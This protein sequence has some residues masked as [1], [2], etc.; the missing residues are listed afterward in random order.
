MLI[1]EIS[2]NHSRSLER[3]MNFVKSTKECGFDAIKFQLFKIDELFIKEVL[4]KSPEHASRRQWEFPLE[5]LEPIS[6]ACKQY[7][8]KLGVTPFYLDAVEEAVEYVD[9]F[10][11]ASYE[12]MW[13]NLHYAIIEHNMPTIISTGMAEL[14]EIIRIKNL[15]ETKSFD[16]EKL[17]FLHCESNYPAN[18][19]TINLKGGKTWLN[20]THK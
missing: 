14:E 2:S 4:E 12:L 11:V 18:Y 13:L 7:D 10:K 20:I 5:F 16:L 1:A 3:C 8:L 15:Y 9:F 6:N 19:E 17:T